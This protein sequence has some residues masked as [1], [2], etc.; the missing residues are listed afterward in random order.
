MP[1]L[2]PTER[3]QGSNQ[4]SHGCYS[5]SYLL[6]HNGNSTKYINFFKERERERGRVCVCVCV[7]VCE[8]EREREREGE[9]VGCELG[10]N[11][12]M[13]GEK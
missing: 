10:E 4:H 8:R 5:D 11:V 1:D 7:C 13:V 9:W 6:S 3:G 2:S 12:S